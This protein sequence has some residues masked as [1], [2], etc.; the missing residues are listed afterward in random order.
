MT[1]TRT[2]AD[3]R[4]GLQK[5]YPPTGGIVVGTAGWRVLFA[6]TAAAMLPITLT[7]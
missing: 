5:S 4:K 6:I 2:T 3:A 7:A 1:L